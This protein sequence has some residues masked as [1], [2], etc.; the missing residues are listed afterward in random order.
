[1]KHMEETVVKAVALSGLSTAPSQV[2]G[3]IRLVPIIRPDAPGDLRLTRRGYKEDMAVVKLDSGWEESGVAYFGYVPHGLVMEWS[4]DGSALAAYGTQLAEPSKRSKFES[5]EVRYLERM[6]KREGP[7][8]LRFLPMHL[9]MEGFLSLYFSGPDI[10]WTEYS[11][12]AIRQGLNPRFEFVFGGESIA[13]FE[14]ALRVFEIHENQVGVLVF[15]ADA[16]ASA[17][18]VSTPD[19]YRALH[20][21]LLSDFYGELI[22]QYALMYKTVL[23]MNV[24]IDE[25]GVDDLTSLRTAVSKV[26]EDWHDFHLVMSGD[27]FGRPVRSQSVY[28]AGPFTLQRFMSDLDLDRENHIGEAVVRD[29]GTLEYLK[30]YRLS[31]AQARRAY[32]LSHLAEAMW[33]IDDAAAKLQTTRDE[34]VLRLEN[35]GFG[36]LLSQPVRNA[37]SKSAWE[38]GRR[39]RLRSRAKCALEM[40]VS[41]AFL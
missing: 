39:C 4:A 21:T 18:V 6:A 7:N 8:T 36:Y 35:A 17:F 3:S 16:L 41:R 25:A 26:R 27:L 37:A 11:K 13:G 23:P 1:M 22:W 10:A 2:C 12:R 29:D 30:T 24:D 31:A 5:A 14:N 40:D 9:A 28:Q 38:L 15:V 34:L 19:D 33:N 32:L 20:R